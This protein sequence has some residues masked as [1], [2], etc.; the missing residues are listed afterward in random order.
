MREVHVKDFQGLHDAVREYPNYAG[1]VYR[2]QRDA[3]WGLM[4]QA[5]VRGLSAETERELFTE[6]KRRA[7]EYLPSIARPISDWDWLAIAQHHG[8]YTRLLDWTRSPLA[9]AYFAVR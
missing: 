8:L 2:G 7:V 6:F 9:V 4:P 1:W 3:G 5:W